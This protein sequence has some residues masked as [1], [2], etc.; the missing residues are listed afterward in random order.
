M[1]FHQFVIK[2][3]NLVFI[4]Y[5]YLS[6]ALSQSCDFSVAVV[7][8]SCGFINI[9]VTSV[10][11]LNVSSLLLAAVPRQRLCEI[12]TLLYTAVEVS[13]VEKKAECST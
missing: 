3:L 8:A 7:G 9:H 4:H 11:K 5:F 12:I 6:P 13:T 2:V 1:C 10:V